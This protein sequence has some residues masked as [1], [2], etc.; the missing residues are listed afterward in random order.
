MIWP[1]KNRGFDM[2]AHSAFPDHR[3]S[4]RIESREIGRLA[5][6][7]A[8]AFGAHLASASSLVGSWTYNEELSSEMQP[9]ASRGSVFRGLSGG[10][11]LGGVHLPIPGS[12]PG[13]SQEQD[14][15]AKDP[16]ALF[17]QTM[18]I[19]EYD[20]RIVIEYAKL[21]TREFVPGKHLGR[22]TKWSGDKLSE[23]YETTTRRVRQR[24]ELARDGRMIVTVTIAPKGDRKRVYKRVFDR[25]ET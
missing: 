9:K 22:K 5:V 18:T 16:D 25:V 19:E 23:A 7:L 8:L 20:D 14:R 13:T 24:Y 21:G 15:S 6:A 1:T 2:N 11:V 12:D 10:I 4:R 3:L 17:C